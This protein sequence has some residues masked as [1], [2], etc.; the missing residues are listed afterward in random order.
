[1]AARTLLMLILIAMVP[2]AAGAEQ[3]SMPT[4]QN[5]EALLSTAIRPFHSCLARSGLPP[6]NGGVAVALELSPAG[7]YP[8]LNEIATPTGSPLELCVG[9]ALA[10]LQS[11]PYAGSAMTIECLLPMSPGRAVICRRPPPPIPA[12][13]SA[14]LPPPPAAPAPQPMSPPPPLPPPS[15]PPA[16]VP[17]PSPTA[18]AVT[19]AE[20][21]QEPPPPPVATPAPAPTSGPLSRVEVRQAL[22]G[23]GERVTMCADVEDAP[24]TLRLR[25]QIAG[26][27][28]VSLL[29]TNPPA[30]VDVV[31]CL[32]GV[33]SVTEVRASGADRIRV[34]FPFRLR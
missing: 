7:G 9:E 11:P 17:A 34:I 15:A 32:S 33:I 19:V 22:A 4:R 18:Q 8:T 28:E 3:A 13:G 24:D 20:V 25:I 14:P 29:E 30:P 16:A 23:I 1:M 31:E 21:P 2:T 26:D 12:A 5:V 6:H 10:D 27:G